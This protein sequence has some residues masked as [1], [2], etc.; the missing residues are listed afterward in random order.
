MSGVV[1]LH[2]CCVCVNA[3][4]YECMLILYSWE[5]SDCVGV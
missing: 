3:H 1:C 5:G 4:V 2:V